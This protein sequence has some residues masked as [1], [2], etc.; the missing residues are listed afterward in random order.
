M[1]CLTTTLL[2]HGDQT[3]VEQSTEVVT[4]SRV[5]VAEANK[6]M[7]LR[8]CAS[9]KGSGQKESPQIE[10]GQ[11]DGPGKV[12]P[13]PLRTQICPHQWFVCL[14]GAPER[15]E[16]SPKSLTLDHTS[17]RGPPRSQLSKQE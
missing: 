9:Q 3:G 13:A 4:W 5:V 6:G 11:W 1:T 8:S 16:E 2:P 10:R 17:S 14:G 12:H 15:R 7:N